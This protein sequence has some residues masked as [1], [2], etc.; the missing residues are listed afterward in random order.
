M[1]ASRQLAAL[2]AVLNV[3]GAR[4]P[5]GKEDAGPREGVRWI[6]KNTI[7][8]DVLHQIGQSNQQQP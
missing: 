6:G 8:R 3:L 1:A 7:V 5:L 2:E 4:V